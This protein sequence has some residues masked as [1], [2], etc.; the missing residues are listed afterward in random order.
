M[1]QR[2]C[3][4]VVKMWQHKCELVGRMAT[5]VQVCRENVVACMQI[6]LIILQH[7]CTLFVRMCLRKCKFVDL[8]VLMIEVVQD[9]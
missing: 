4:L 2:E 1:S 3:I 7:E 8:K 5:Q 6:G 9:L